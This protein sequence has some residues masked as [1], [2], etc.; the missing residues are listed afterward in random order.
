MRHAFHAIG[1]F[2]E[3]QRWLRVLEHQSLIFEKLDAQP[4]GFWH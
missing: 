4:D 3:G 2:I 1:G